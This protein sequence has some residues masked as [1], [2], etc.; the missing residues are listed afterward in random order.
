MKTG[1]HIARAL[2]CGAIVAGCVAEKPEV[3]YSGLALHYHYELNPEWTNLFGAEVDAL[4]ILA[5]DDSGLFHES[6]EVTDPAQLGDDNLIRLPLPD[7]RWDILTWGGDMASFGIGGMVR[8][9]GD[10]SHDVPLEKGVTRID[11]ARLWIDSHTPMENGGKLVTDHLSDLYYGMVERVEATTATTPPVTRQVDL[12]RNTNTLRV[13][14]HGLPTRSATRS[15][16]RADDAPVTATADMTNERCRADNGI[17]DQVR[18]TRHVRTGT[19]AAGLDSLAIDLTVMR[20]FTDDATSRLTLSGG[21]LDDLGIAADRLSIPI[22][23][24]ILAS[25]KYN[26]QTDLDRENLYVFEFFL[27]GTGGFDLY[28]NSWQVIDTVIDI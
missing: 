28:I 21:I 15:A 13:V 9:Q 4:N 14:L 20:L 10:T 2:L 25:D 11:D 22:V 24:T 8:D 12:M 7:G 3:C 17:C 5:F 23:P 27:N 16:T 19:P 1:L 26:D 18:A 6:F